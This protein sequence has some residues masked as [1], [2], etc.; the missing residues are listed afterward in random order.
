M[1]FFI[2]KSSLEFGMN[3]KVLLI[4]VLIEC[5]IELRHVFDFLGIMLFLFVYM[6]SKGGASDSL[7]Y[8]VFCFT[9]LY[10]LYHQLSKLLTKMSALPFTLKNRF[11]YIFCNDHQNQS[12]K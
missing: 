4:F 12:S 1:D 5:Y 6:I 10:I 11:L 7:F 3:L 8:A 2:D 9:P